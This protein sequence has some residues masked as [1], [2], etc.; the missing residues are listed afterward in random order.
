MKNTVKRQ[1][2]I[3]LL[4]LGVTTWMMIP[5]A[6]ADGGPLSLGAR[7]VDYV[8]ADGSAEYMGGVQ[9]RLQLPLFFGVEGSVDYRREAFGG[10]TTHEWPVQLSGLLYLPKIILVQ[11]FLLGGVG[12]YNTTTK[13]PDGFSDTQNRFGPHA[14]AG[15]EVNLSSRWFLDA[16]YRYVWLNEL[17]T[18]NAQGVSEDIRDSG[19][20]ITAG[21]NYRL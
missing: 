14:G 21:L 19:H 9:A 5:R 10:T 3:S 6:Y 15:V 1:G 12:W 11:P 17:H 2:C 4:L 18:T 8:P 7:G 20:M 16:T 13:G